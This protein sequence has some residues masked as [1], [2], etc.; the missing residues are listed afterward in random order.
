MIYHHHTKIPLYSG[1]VK[2]AVATAL[3]YDRSDLALEWLEQGHCLVWNQLN[4]LHT[5]I[6]NICDR[7]FFLADYFVNVAR[8]LEDYGTHSSSTISSDSTIAENIHA[9][10]KTC[11]HTI[12]AAEYNQ[13]LEEIWSLPDFYDFLQP[14]N[15]TNILSSVPSNGPVIIFNLYKT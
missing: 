2:S 8:A 5:P 15:A 11:N 4:Q 14:P 10:D 3:Q 6:H 12:L 7:N 13:L 9:Q 1:L